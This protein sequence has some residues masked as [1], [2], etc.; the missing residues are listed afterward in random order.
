[1]AEKATIDKMIPDRTPGPNGH[2]ARE[3]REAPRDGA[4]KRRVPR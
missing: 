2:G 3:P 1:M 4:G